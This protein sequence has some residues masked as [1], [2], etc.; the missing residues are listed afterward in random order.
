[1]ALLLTVAG[2]FVVC[3]CGWGLGLEGGSSM[4]CKKA[5]RKACKRHASKRTHSV[6]REHIL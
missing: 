4:G 1:M 3:V 6:L 5:C 2:I